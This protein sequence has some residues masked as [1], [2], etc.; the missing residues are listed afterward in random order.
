MINLCAVCEIP[1]LKNYCI[2]KTEFFKQID[3]MAEDAVE[4]GS[5]SNTIKYTDK[6]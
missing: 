5:P 3:K 4:S 2:D 1:T 6:K